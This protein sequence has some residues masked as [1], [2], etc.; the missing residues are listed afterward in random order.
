[1]V[2][3]LG[4][5]QH[6]V[7]LLKLDDSLLFLNHLLAVVRKQESDPQL[8]KCFSDRNA[9]FPAFVVHFIAKQILLRAS[10]FGRYP[11][12]LPRFQRLLDLYFEL[13]DP[14]VGD[15]NWK[16]SDPTGCFVR[17][18]AQQMPS[19]HRNMIQKY[20]LA[21]GLF[22]DAGPITWPFNYD[23]REDIEGTLGI[24]IEQFMTMGFLCLALRTARYPCMGTFT[25]NA[26]A[27]AFAQGITVSVPEV[28][29]E[30]LP[31]VACDQNTFRRT[32][33]REVY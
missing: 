13:D 28:W 10:N 11:L 33:D 21:L 12:S 7:G 24:T 22:R 9:P 29:N 27:E 6:E 19:Q 26:L 32:S 14:I 25:P 5:I 30:F 4:Q 2:D 15:P 20:G 8:E 23:L 18:L 16:H 1:M 31:K 3:A 17:M